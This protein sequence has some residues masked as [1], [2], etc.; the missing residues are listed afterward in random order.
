MIG[1]RLFAKPMSAELYAGSNSTLFSEFILKNFLRETDL[2]QKMIF[3]TLFLAAQIAAT[4]SRDYY[5]DDVQDY[6]LLAED[7]WM[8]PHSYGLNII[9]IISFFNSK[10]SNL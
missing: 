8:D 1:S 6:D 5:S 9:T 7:S 2:V 10:F 4:D 3:F